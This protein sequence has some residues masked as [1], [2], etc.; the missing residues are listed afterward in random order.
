MY[1][2]HAVKEIDEL[3][4]QIPRRRVFRTGRNGQL[5]RGALLYVITHTGELW[6]RRSPWG[7][8]ILKGV[9]KIITLFSYVV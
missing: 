9:K 3:R 6:H 8:E 5:D 2:G 1:V 7:A 4:P